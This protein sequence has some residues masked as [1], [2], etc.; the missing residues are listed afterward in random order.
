MNELLWVLTLLFSFLG[1]LLFYKLFGKMGL[2]V[3]I[4]IATIICNI[5]TTK[6]VDIFGLE[7]S[8]GTILYGSTFLATDIINEV[9]GKEQAKKTI[10]MGFL[11]MVFMT[12]LMTL[13]LL[14]TPSKSDFANDSLK[15]IFTLNIRI[16]IAS[17][18]GFML[19]Q[20][21]DTVLYNK[22]KKKY[23]GLW[24][25]NNVSTIVSQLLDTFIFVS[26][27]YIGKLDFKVMLTIFITMYVLKVLVAIL[28]TPFIYL[29]KNIKPV[30]EIK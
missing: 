22:I 30:K 13:A 1:V 26:I 7:T 19:S 6:I 8:L 3:W 21:T 11:V 18:I 12:I 10:L 24:I 16:T 28:D 17:I 14:Y 2:F 15:L 27:T 20:L 29:S 9:Y 23:K 4:S 25:R 5:Q